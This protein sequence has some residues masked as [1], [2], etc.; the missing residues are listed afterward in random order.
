M[1]GKRWMR[2]LAQSPSPE[3]TDLLVEG[4][5]AYGAGA[6]EQQGSTVITYVADVDDP[7]RTV[8]EI[9]A[10]LHPFTEADVSLSWDWL[11][12]EDWTR[13]WR[14]GL[15]ARRV[16]DHF[17]ITPTWVDANA[18][19]DDIV[20]TIDPKMAF[21]TGEHATTR[22]MLRLMEH[23]INQGD[24]VLDVGAGSAIL[25]IAAAKLGAVRAD[26]VE[27]D[28]DAIENAQEN[29]DR[30]DVSKQVVLSCEL[31]NVPFLQ[32]RSDHYDV[33]V[34]NVLSG[35]LKPLLTAFAHSLR[36]HGLLLLSGILRD[37][38]DEMIA[39]AA[40]AGFDVVAED[41]EEEWWSCLCRQC[42]QS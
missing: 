2:V 29:I 39:A 35:V 8:A 41:R 23:R 9:Q 4:L 27:S 34:A 5:I 16:G 10:F 21:G 36:P 24:I 30:N 14:R 3:H 32:V 25:A 20:I 6:A 42:G 11:E 17:I 7:E 22:G 19:A 40:A 26:A 28:P 38:A 37:E 12:D 18:D 13:E 1:S 31:V 15:G 33:I